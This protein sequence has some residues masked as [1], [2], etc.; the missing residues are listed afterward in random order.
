MTRTS[1]TKWR[2][3]HALTLVEILVALTLVAVVLLPVVIGLTQAL[4]ATSETSITAAATSIGREKV[5]QIKA[6]TRRPDFDF[7]DLS[8]EPRVAADLK[9]GDSFFEVEVT[10]EIVRP[11]DEQRSGLKKVQVCVYQAGTDRPIT[12]LTT[13]FTPAGT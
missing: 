8:S 1:A 5:E 3:D 4:V 7:A 6:E 2:G 10:V 11:N 12:A 13:Y 9:P